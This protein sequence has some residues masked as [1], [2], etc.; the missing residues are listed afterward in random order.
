MTASEYLSRLETALGA[1][2]RAEREDFLREMKSHIDELESRRPNDDEGTIVAGLTP[3][4]RL[5]EGLLSAEEIGAGAPSEAPG[6]KGGAEPAEGGQGPRS[7]RSGTRRRRPADR[8]RSLLEA[9][10][11]FGGGSGEEG[12]REFVRDIGAEGITALRVELLASDLRVGPSEDGALHLRVEGV[13]D[14]GQLAVAVR[15]GAVELVEQGGYRHGIDSV[16]LA[17]PACIGELE[18]SLLSG[19]LELE[20]LDCDVSARTK[21]GD[22]EARGMGGD[23]AAKTASGDIDV[24]AVEGKIGLTTASGEIEAR[25]IAGP[26]AAKSV[27]GGVTASWDGAFAGAVLATV[28]GDIALSFSGEPDARLSLFTRTGRIEVEGE[29]AKGGDLLLG[30]GG[31]ELKASSLSGNI[32]VEW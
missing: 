31:G 10:A 9:L 6:L 12:R 15:E 21:S 4:E 26:F 28:S 14:E 18:L 22:V 29:G 3:P 13:T 23:F 24:E 25:K 8:L 27:S 32:E 20:G 2:D 30:A 7:E 11:D 17:L 19:N 16:E 1:M 5:A